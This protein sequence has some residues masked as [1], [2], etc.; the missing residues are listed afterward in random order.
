[1]VPGEVVESRRNFKMGVLKLLVCQR[2]RK[3]RETDVTRK[4]GINAGKNVLREGEGMGS[5]A[6][7]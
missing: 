2:S 3:E 1:M 4:V 6:Q 7:E 5:R